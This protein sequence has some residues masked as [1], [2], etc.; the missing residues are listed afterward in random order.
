MLHIQTLQV[1]TALSEEAFAH[2]V[3]S[4]FNTK[5]VSSPQSQKHIFAITLWSRADSSAQVLMLRSLGTKESIGQHNDNFTDP[6]QT[7]FK[8]I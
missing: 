7:C 2:H 3:L 1:L 8:S 6:H 5:L 4:T